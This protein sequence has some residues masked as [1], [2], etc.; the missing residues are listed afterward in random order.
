MQSNTDER[1]KCAVAE[2]EADKLRADG[3]CECDKGDF[4][5]FD[6]FRSGRRDLPE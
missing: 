4:P 5:C 3:G 6:C 1:K 2:P